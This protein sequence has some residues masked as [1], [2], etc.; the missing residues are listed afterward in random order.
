[1]W[2]I[3]FLRKLIN[4]PVYKGEYAANRAYT[5]EVQKPSKDGLTMRTVKKT[6]YRPEEEWILVPV[7]AIVDAD[8]WQRANEMLQKNKQMSRRNAKS[9]Y[10]LTGLLRCA[11]CGYAVAGM[12][13][14]ENLKGGRR[15]DYY[16]YKC[17]T[18]A[19]YIRQKAQGIM[20]HQG[21][22]SCRKLDAAVWAAVCQ[23]LLQPET[24]IVALES[25]TF[26]EQQIQ[27]TQQLAFL[28]KQLRE[29]KAQSER[30]TRAYLAGAFDEHEFAD[31]RVTLKDEAERLSRELEKLR[32][33][34]ITREQFEAQ[35]EYILAISE[36]LNSNG[37][38]VDPPF[39]LKRRILKMLVDTIVVN[40]REGWFT[41]TGSI[42]SR[43]PLESVSA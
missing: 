10:L 23:L 6:M 5:A 12:R 36:E 19:Y 29:N 13:H 9:E 20:C 41:L 4:N 34:Q 43:F 26:D 21:Y 40:Q 24:L 35:K 7:P 8:T 3:T 28:E 38:L 16:G 1:M 14:K 2:D 37:T 33:K 22:I 15:T 11:E 31:L 32:P 42:Q 25:S 18:H 17:A 30:L 27:T 39:E